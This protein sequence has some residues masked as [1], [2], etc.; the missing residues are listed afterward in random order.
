MAYVRMTLLT[1]KHGYLII[2]D[3][4]RK[5]FFI[6]YKRAVGAMLNTHVEH[7]FSIFEGSSRLLHTLRIYCRYL[8]SLFLLVPG[9][10]H[11]NA[12]Y[13]EFLSG[14]ILKIFSGKVLI[15]FLFLVKTLIVGTR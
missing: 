14:L 12:I 9:R 2:F 15:F 4:V 6:L 11:A 3:I 5:H 10:K 7:I 1:E 13:R 8:L